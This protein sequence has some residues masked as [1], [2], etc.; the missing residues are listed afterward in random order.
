MNLEITGKLLEKG[1]TIQVKDTF[2]KREFVLELIEEFNGQPSQYVN[3]AKMQLVQNKCELLDRFTE[4]DVLKV[5]FNIKGNRYERDGKVS[6]F[7]NLD[8]WRVER[9]DAAN[10]QQGGGNW[11]QNPYQNSGN[12]APSG[13]Q[14]SNPAPVA[15]T[16]STDG[17]DGLPF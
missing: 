11:N 17:D 2:K 16:T 15:P 14:Q 1:E 7:S 8:A 6:Y 3:Y 13:F 5:N 12:P 10:N 9:A 4:G